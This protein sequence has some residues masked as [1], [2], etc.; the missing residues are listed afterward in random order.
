[1]LQTSVKRTQLLL[2]DHLTAP[3]FTEVDCQKVLF[4][5][6][7]LCLAARLRPVHDRHHI[8]WHRATWRQLRHMPLW[9]DEPIDG[10]TLY[11]DGTFH[12]NT[13]RA[14]AGVVLLIHTPEGL[15]WG[16]YITAPCLG[17]ATAPRAEASALLLAGLWMRQLLAWRTTPHTWFEIAFDC[18]HTANIARGV[19]APAHNLDIFVVLRSLIQWLE[20]QLPAPIS[21]THH[22]S[23]Q[24]HPWNEAADTV[25]KQALQDN[26]FTAQLDDIFQLCTFQGQDSCAVQW[27]WLIEKSLR[28]DS[29][30][31]T[32]L[33]YKW[34]FDV[35]S[36]FMATPVSDIQPAIE[37]RPSVLSADEKHSQLTLRVATANVLTLFPGHDDHGSFLGARAESI[38]EQ[39]LSAN[40]QIIGLQETRAILSGHSTLDAYHVLSGPAT[41]RGRGGVQLWLQKSLRTAA[42]PVAVEVADLRILHATSRRLVVRW[43]NPSIHIIFV[44]A[45]APDDDDDDALQ[46][47][48]DATTAAIPP[49]YRNW[50]TVAL[51]DTNSRVGG[52]QSDAIGPHQA[53]PENNKGTFLHSWLTQHDLFLPQT[54]E[55][56]HRGPAATWTHPTGA[57]ARMDFIA[58]SSDLASSPITTWVAS[59]IDLAISRQD[60][61]CVCA[62]LA[63]SFYEVDRRERDSR[64]SEKSSLVPPDVP[65]ATDV[66]THAARLQGWL[67]AGRPKERK[68]RKAH[69]T[70]ATKTLIEAKRHHWKRIGE[71]RR[72]VRHGFLQQMFQ[73]WRTK[74]RTDVS[75]RPWLRHCD[76]SLAW[77]LWVYADLAPRVVAAVRED[78]A[79]FYASLA[80]QAGEA[81]RKGCQAL[82]AAI[83][84]A[85]PRWRCKRRANLRCT[86]PTI[87]EQLHHYDALE[88]GSATTFETLL[89]ACHTHQR[90]AA[91]ELPLAVSLADLPSRLDVEMHGCRIKTNK[92]AGIDSVPPAILKSAC[93]QHA[94]ILHRLMLKI[95][96]LGAEPIQ[97]KGGILHPIAKKEASQNIDGMRGI[98]LIDGIGK[99]IHSHLRR[100]FVPQLQQVRLPMQLGG[101][102]RCSTL[103][104]T[105]YVRAF[106]D[107]AAQHRLSSAVIFIDIRS[108]FHSMIRTFVFSNDSSLPPPLRQVLQEAGLDVAQI[109]RNLDQACPLDKTMAPSVARLLQDAH[110]HTWYTLGQ[111]ALTHRTERGSRPGSPLA[112]VAFNALMVQVLQELQTRLD[113]Y[114]PLQLAFGHLGLQAL[115]VSW[116]DDLALPVVSL[117]AEKLVP[118]IQCVLTMTIQ[119]CEA[120]GLTLNLKPK[121]T[122]VVPAFRGTGAPACRSTLFL[123]QFAKIPLPET[124]QQVRCVSQYEHLGTTYQA[125]GGIDSE[126]R[127]RVCRA[128]HAHRQVRKVILMNQHLSVST[129]LRLLEALILPVLLHGAGNWPLLSTAQLHRLT[130][131]Y[132]RWIRSIVCNG[133]WTEDQ[134]TDHHLLLQWRL[135]SIAMRLAKLRLLYAF[136]WI[137]DAPRALIDIVTATADLPHSW[138]AGLRQAL[139]WASQIDEAL[140]VGD[141]LTDS[142]EH[143]CQW[144]DFNQK[145]G[146]ARAR[147][148]FRHALLQG[149]V[150]GQTMTL[151]YEMQRVLCRRGLPVERA[152]SSPCE[153]EVRSE[154]RFCAK[155]FDQPQALRAHLWSAHGEAT[156]ERLFMSSTTC[157]ACWKCFW[158]VNRLQI[159]LHQ[160]RQQRGGCYERLTWT[161]SPWEEAIHIEETD[162]ALLPQRLPAA[163]VPH[164][165]S[166]LAQQC[167]SR[168]VA[169]E[170]WRSLW[171]LEGMTF[172]YDE[173][174]GQQCRTLYDE[175][176]ASFVSIDALLWHLTT[177]ADGEGLPVAPSGMGSWA[178]A[179]WMLDDLRF[180]RFPMFSV[181]VFGQIVREVRMIVN[182]SPIGRLVCWRRRM[183]EAFLGHRDA[184]VIT[185]AVRLQSEREPI[186]DCVRGQGLLLAPLLQPRF[187]FHNC[188]HGSHPAA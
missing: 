157:N 20:V 122:E 36:P 90:D 15:R 160:S 24:Q 62:D 45:H 5:R 136:H 95:W 31:P 33:Q 73:A 30:A 7:Q 163:E 118:M 103:F 144:L 13:T 18:E 6:N 152:L 12:R 174:W 46:S 16:G 22:H 106:T 162:V 67:R 113:Q 38:A 42:G 124:T 59:D 117:A 19:Q 147:R 58:V 125:D 1:M 169:L 76:H 65:W 48:W 150:M 121:K 68:W 14:A 69:L 182:L 4:L 11:T 75:Y 82:W 128:V 114:M 41:K 51:M 134:M 155:S 52:I 139:V 28:R 127:H 88:A 151:H 17:T 40:I 50:T 94:D 27:L 131:P 100:Q 25:C 98:M 167:L 109:Q 135:P 180:S 10:M 70:P 179:L 63:L 23:H 154:C 188:H 83:Q 123:D 137:A 171:E 86:G 140:Y 104:A 138:F 161:Q 61:A 172:E 165:Q 53:D 129:R 177:L 79:Q 26:V 54:W 29:D 145:H 71:I 93:H 168:D 64:L 133:C 119:V 97:C 159:H 78:D 2:D 85:L 184:P 56:Y 143:V 66:H 47:F 99:L 148:I 80:E 132:I 112:D 164:V 149:H 92:A 74:K 176:L 183:D 110:Q 173:A 116:V 156:S 141:P 130:T 146:P 55:Q 185:T 39:F 81:S 111:T 175:A 49:A 108:A 126:T 101:F 9:V 34:R 72:S 21:W 3:R 153:L 57:V 91:D 105:Q 84:H 158:T 35:S 120:F 43:A 181:D 89:D 178:L 102:A 166:H 37:R 186:L 60:H 187:Q 32:L 87:A 77:H 142:V 170:H 44:V 107:L 96:L 8:W 115:P